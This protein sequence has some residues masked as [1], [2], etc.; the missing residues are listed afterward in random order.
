MLAVH[1]ERLA[2]WERISSKTGHRPSSN[3]VDFV[4]GV[5]THTHASQQLQPLLLSDSARALQLGHK[6]GLDIATGLLPLE[7]LQALVRCL[8]LHWQAI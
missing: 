4:V 2:K 1:T 6:L 7:E 3:V 8:V 5:S